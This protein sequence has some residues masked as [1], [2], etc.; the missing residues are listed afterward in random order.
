MLK[1]LIE[2]KINSLSCFFTAHI[3]REP[4]FY[5]Q[6][7]DAPSQLYKRVCPSMLSSVHPSVGPYIPRFFR[8]ILGA[9]C[10]VYPALLFLCFLFFLSSFPLFFFFVSFSFFSPS[11]SCLQNLVPAYKH[12]LQ[13]CRHCRSLASKMKVWGVWGQA[14]RWGSL[15]VRGSKQNVGFEGGKMEIEM[16]RKTMNLVLLPCGR[17]W[18]EFLPPSPG[19]TTNCR[20]LRKTT[21]Q[22]RKKPAFL[23]AFFF[24]LA[25]LSFFP[26]L[27][28]PIFLSLCLPLYR[29]GVSVVYFSCLSFPI[30]CI[31]LSQ[32]RL[33]ARSQTW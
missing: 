15:R 31:S 21:L 26:P 1:I 12:R 4:S 13:D 7:L 10:A 32:L 25:F 6:F 23:Q 5:L 29:F 8:R 20:S 18:V 9:S 28:L 16:R 24:H 11:L 2:I 33:G 27:S 17:S 14:V 30:H 19:S 22:T 3:F